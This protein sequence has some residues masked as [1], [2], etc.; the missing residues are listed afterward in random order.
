MKCLDTD[1]DL[2]VESALGTV[3]WA[4]PYFTLFSSALGTNIFPS[5][6]SSTLLFSHA[7]LTP[8]RL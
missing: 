1:W 5:S 3:F 8:D 2:T 6:D 7:S 4:S